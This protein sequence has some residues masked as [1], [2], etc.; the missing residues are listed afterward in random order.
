MHRY[1]QSTC[2]EGLKLSRQN[3]FYRQQK[4]SLTTIAR[5][6]KQT[7]LSCHACSHIL[8]KAKKKEKSLHKNSQKFKMLAKKFKVHFFLFQFKDCVSVVQFIPISKST[9][10]RGGSDYITQ[11]GVCKNEALLITNIYRV[12]LQ[13]YFHGAFFLQYLNYI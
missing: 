9:A 2:H 5:K 4:H 13:P 11:L 6:G 10:Q 12:M 7:F 1:L 8:P 3:P